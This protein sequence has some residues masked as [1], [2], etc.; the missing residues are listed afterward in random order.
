MGLR[1]FGMGVSYYRLDLE[2][3]LVRII[4]LFYQSVYFIVYNPCRDIGRMVGSG[5]VRVSKMVGM[6][7][8]LLLSWVIQR[9]EYS[10]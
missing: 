5:T 4:F 3:I 7:L 1:G 2:N 10:S 6:I 9:H 8:D